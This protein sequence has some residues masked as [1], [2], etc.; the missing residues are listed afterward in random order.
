MEEHKSNLYFSVIIVILSTLLIFVKVSHD[1][2]MKLLDAN[3]EL[4][5]ALEIQREN[6]EVHIQEIVDKYNTLNDKYFDLFYTNMELQK[7]LNEVETPVYDYTEE[8]IYMLA[9][10][11]EAEAGHYDN[12]KNSQKYVTQVILNRLQSGK[13]P[14]TIEK[15]IY[16]KTGGVPQFSVAW[17]GSMNREV[18]PET[19]ANVYSVLVN[20]TDMPEYVC[21]FYSS[22]VTENWVNTL[23]TYDIVE[24]TVFAYENKEDY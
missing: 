16:Q 19:L 17:N 4:S 22:S 24:G 6:Y 21:Y 20:G 8:E 23:N 9:Q 12:H 5:E 18:E 2:T 10:C 11:V 14:N 13:F 15:V 3:N 1:N 7:K